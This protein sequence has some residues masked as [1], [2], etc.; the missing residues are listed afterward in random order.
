VSHLNDLGQPIGAAVTDWTPRDRPAAA[1]MKGHYCRL[2]PLDRVH[3]ADSLFEALHT[4]GSGRQW[5]YFAYGPLED[6]AA[7]ADF[8]DIVCADPELVPFAICAPDTGAAYGMVTFARIQPEIG[9]IEVG[10]IMFGPTLQRTAA[11]TEAMYL[12]ASHVF[13]EL[14][15]RRYEWKCDALNA[16]SI[17]AASRLGFQPEGIWR[18]ATIYKGRTRDTAWLTL[19]D[20]D[21]QTVRPAIHRWLDPG[22]FA[23]D[24]QQRTA[25]S[26]LLS[27]PFPEEPFTRSSR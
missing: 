23:E 25:L 4:D 1:T 7:F 16:A 20:Q 17:A 3:H 14:G 2:E 12:M 19:T 21:W 8:L 15:Y 6:V 5:T 27:G 24:G 18:N 13:D 26:K 11:A 10:G 9:S 22:N